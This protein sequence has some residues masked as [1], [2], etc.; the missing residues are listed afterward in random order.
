[1]KKTP[2]KIT[3]IIVIQ[4]PNTLETADSSLLLNIVGAP[5]KSIFLIIDLIMLLLLCNKDDKNINNSV[6]L[7]TF[8]IKKNSP[9]EIIN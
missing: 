4:P 5:N 8:I 2:N 1:M 6:Y 7:F 9:P 3:K